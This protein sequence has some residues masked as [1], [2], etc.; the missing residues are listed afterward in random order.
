MKLFKKLAILSL[1]LL[2]TLSLGIV[3]ACGGDISSSSSESN[4]SEQTSSS[5]A[6]ESSTTENSSSQESSSEENSS[7]STEEDTESAFVY[8]VKVQN[9]TGYGFKGVTVKLYN[10]DTEVASATTSASGYA[11]FGRSDIIEL[12]NYMVRLSDVPKGYETVNADEDYITG[13][14]IGWEGVM[15]IHPTGVIKE[16]AP[17]GTS[18]KLGDVMYD[19]TVTTSDGD[20]F[21]L[22]EV[23]KEKEMVLLNFWATWCTPCK[24]EFPA[25]NNAYISYQD[26]VEVLAISTSDAMRAVETFKS[27]NGL[28]FKMTSNADSGENLDAMFSK[29]GIPLSVIVDRYG[30]ITYYHEGSMEKATDFT[31]RFDKF[32]GMNYEPTIII[33]SGEDNEGGGSG[34]ESTNQIK[35]T[36][37]APALN[38]IKQAFA[39][40]SNDFT[41]T[42]DNED[43]YAWPWLIENEQIYSPVANMNLNDNYSTLKATFMAGP[44]DA[45]FF[46]YMVHTEEAADILYVLIDGVPIQRLSG[47]NNT[48]T[49]T[50]NFSA[51]VF[52]EDYDEEGEHEIVFLYIK[53][54]SDSIDGESV[55]L[56]NLRLVQDADASTLN[57]NVFRHAANI[58]NEDEN[59]TSL[60]KYYA[61]PVYNEADGYYHVG[62]KDGPLLLANL[63]LSSRWSDTSIWLLAYN[64]FIIVDGINF[65]NELE[66]HAWGAS[67]PVP[68]RSL[69]YG[70]TPVTEELKELLII[71][72]RS[73]YVGQSGYKNWTGA[74]HENEWL[75]TCAYFDNY[76][77]AAPIEDPMKTITFFAAEQVYEGVNTAKVLF[78]MTPRGFKYKFIPEKSGVYNIYSNVEFGSQ[79]DPVCFYFRETTTEFEYYDNRLHSVEGDD[80]FNFYAYMEAG[81]TYYF[82]MTTFGDQVAEYDFTIKLHGDTYSYMENC[83]TME[84]YNEITNETFLLDGIQYAYSDPEKGGDGYYHVVDENGNLGSII[85]VDMLRPTMFFRNNSLYDTAMDALNYSEEKRAF[86]VDGV[87]YSETIAIYGYLADVKGFTP[88]N[89]ELMDILKKITAKYDGIA[90]SWQ[91]LCYYEVTLGK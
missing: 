21:T 68:G 78:A 45:I 39:Q 10:G 85:Y 86:Y 61:T 52:K 70:Y 44:G 74:W 15:Q 3:S 32:L 35:P 5:S 14:W 24:R 63:I 90:D 42:W 55:R 38:D 82:A 72:T 2:T 91:M 53:D 12:K 50:E 51:Y 6:E 9:A 49:W 36:V 87:D 11:T 7:S 1:A 73:K 17:I 62:T 25:M 18:Y 41:F 47:T 89:Q 69:T 33:G 59:A 54:G 13:D 57:A 26:Q 16:K 31:S 83:A 56:K 75:E 28:Q 66:N 88:L 79:I 81:K 58:I 80:N 46:D 65:F 76:G 29:I 77:S 4:S 48:A 43:E 37:D 67:Q 19:F 71:A 27:S 30:V 64:N 84:S 8:R 40:G 23:L 34:E 22:S 20:K 60:Y